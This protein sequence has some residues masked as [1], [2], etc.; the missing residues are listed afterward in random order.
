LPLLKY[1]WILGWT[2]GYFIIY[3]VCFH[4]FYQPYVGWK[5]GYGK[6]LSLGF[7]ASGIGI[8]FF[9]FLNPG[10]RQHYYLSLI[11]E[12]L[13][14]IGFVYINRDLF[15]V[16]LDTHG[17]NGEYNTLLEQY[18]SQPFYLMDSLNSVLLKQFTD[19]F[20]GRL[21]KVRNWIKTTLA[22][23]PEARKIFAYLVITLLFMIFEI[24][25]GFLE[26]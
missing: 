14:L 12:P 8:I 3:D 2:I 1:F 11:I 6:S 17:L 15:Q 5:C 19:S 16:L 26:R 25:M 10:W 23:G 13:L 4:D 20:Q 9:S 18:L 7:I 21:L 22:S 24:V